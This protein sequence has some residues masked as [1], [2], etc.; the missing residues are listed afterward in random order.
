MNQPLKQLQTFLCPLYR[1]NIDTDALIPTS[2]NTRI[3]AQGFGESLFA[4]W[5]YDNVTK[6]SLNPK[7]ILNQFPYSQ[8]QILA[9]GNNF[10]CG[11]SRES[12]VWALRDYG[13]RVIFAL[14]F[15][16]TFTRNCINNGILPLVLSATIIEAICQFSI[17]YSETMIIF[18]LGKQTIIAD[19]QEYSFSIDPYVK[20]LLINAK[21][22]LTLLKQNQ[23]LIKRRVK[24]LAT[25]L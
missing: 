24:T 3:S 6:R 5:R 16:E 25:F 2:E 13:F 19:Q 14:S 18:D 8:A 12:A 9:A 4:S 20:D 23:T 15:N 7:F 22:E 17:D 11:S 1:D 21:T 10:G